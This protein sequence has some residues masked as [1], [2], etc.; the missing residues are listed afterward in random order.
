VIRALLTAACVAT[1]QA[2]APPAIYAVIVGYNGAAEGLPELHYADDDALRFAMLFRGITSAENV[3]LL[4]EP[5]AQTQQTFR[6]AGLALPASRAPTRTQLFGALAEL[7]ARLE[8]LGPDATV[9]FIYAGHGLPGRLLLQPEGATQAAITGHELRAALADLPV[10]RATV[11]LDSCR[12]QSLFV[13]RGSSGA[14][15]DLSA[16]IDALERRAGAVKIGVIA[17]AGSNHPTG[18]T[19]DLHAG[20]FSHV[21]QSG[22][23]G[24]ADADGDN[25]ITFG[26]LAAFVAF[27]TESFAGQRPWFDPPGGDLRAPAM[28]HRHHDTRLVLPDAEAGR[29]RVET[30]SGLPVFAEFNKAPGKPMSLVLPPGRYRLMEVSP[31]AGL[32]AEIELREGQ[33]AETSPSL[34]VSNT[35]ANQLRGW[36]D[37]HSGFMAPFTSDAVT[38]LSVG[39]QSAREPSV[40][41]TDW[42]HAIDLDYGLGPAPFGVSGIEQG[43]TGDYRLSLGKAL[44]G[45]TADF[46]FGNYS[47]AL[48]PYGIRRSGVLL[49]GGARYALASGL[50]ISAEL[51]AGLRAVLHEEDGKVTS[52]DLTAP[53]VLCALRAEYPL[54]PPFAAFLDVR[55][56]V[57]WVKVDGNRQPFFTPNVSL[58]IAARL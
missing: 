4:T 15:P 13:E 5:D 14:G 31:T 51:G 40:S 16:E 6:D 35:G 27:N 28:D 23:A 32:S 49:D 56:E 7:R 33:P 26:E 21:L 8:K 22:L 2:Q 39:Y 45:V 10:E 42:R 18:E 9:Y 52:G 38:V 53:A 29:F 11:F 25:V 54:P 43:V 3:W 48:G 44:V 37:E 50:E 57:D 36:S 41:R 24:A 19:A 17:A 20:Y 1:P 46:R 55:G 30:M 47:G 34:L 58:G 12:A